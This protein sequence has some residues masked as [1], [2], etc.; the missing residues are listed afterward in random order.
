ML[1]RTLALSDTRR[2]APRVHSP[3]S[4]S[5]AHVNQKHLKFMHRI[6]YAVTQYAF[7]R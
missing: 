3:S 2:A 4:L 5:A 6:L 7:I 1:A